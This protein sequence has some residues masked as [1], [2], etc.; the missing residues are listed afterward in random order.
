[1]KSGIYRITNPTNGKIYIG[2]S[3]DIENRWRKHVEKLNKGN[4]PN[5]HLQ[6]SWNKRTT[7]FVFEKLELCIIEDLLSREQYYIDNL[8]PQYNIELNAGSSLGVKRRQETIDKIRVATT[9]RKQSQETIDKRVIK[10][11]GKR[12]LTPLQR[13]SYAKD[14]RGKNNPIFKHGWTKQVQA[15]KL[16]NIGSKRDKLVGRKISVK[17]S[18]PICQ[19]DFSNNIIREWESAQEV[20]RELGWSN[21]AINRVCNNKKKTYKGYLWKFK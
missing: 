5:I 17:L 4:H 6:R 1:M 10:L 20:E 18:K 21:S 9:G 2:S 15:M 13:E 12:N 11:K 19:L 3:Y 8:K 14:K 16:A 7:D